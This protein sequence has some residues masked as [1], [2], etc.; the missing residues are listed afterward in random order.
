ML[1]MFWNYVIPDGST[2]EKG[3]DMGVAMFWNYVIPDG[4]TTRRAE[5]MKSRR[6]LELCHSRWFYYHKN[7]CVRY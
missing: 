2:T 3:L 6:V 4:S 5:R 7:G 1:V